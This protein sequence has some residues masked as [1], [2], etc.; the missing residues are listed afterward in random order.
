MSVVDPVV[1]PKL[2]GRWPPARR[3]TLEIMTGRRRSGLV[4]RRG[5]L[6]RRALLAAD[7]IGLV[8]AFFVTQWLFDPT[9]P[10]PGPGPAHQAFAFALTLPLWVVLAK[11]Y[12][13]YDRDE[14]RTDTGIADDF[15]GVFNLVSVGAWIVY[16]GLSLSGV[17]HPSLTKIGTF[18]AVAIVAIPAARGAARNICRSHPSYIQNALIVGAGRVGQEVARKL[19]QHPEYGIDLVGFVDADRVI[20]LP[21]GTRSVPVVGGPDELTDLVVRYDVERVIFAFGWTSDSELLPVVGSLADLGVQI[22]IVP[23][24]FEIIGEN[25]DLHS[26]EGLPLLALRPPR[27]SR[28]S[29]LLKRT[30]DVVGSLVAVVL[31]MPF[32]AAI[33]IAIKLDSRGPVVFRQVR[34]GR[35]QKRFRIWKFRTMVADA[36]AR[37]AEFAHLNKH[38][39]AG[40]DPRMFKIPDDPR[41]T[42]VGRL[43]RRYSLDELP[44]LVNV[45]LGQMSLVGP[46]PLIVDEHAHVNGWKERRLSLKP[47]ITGVWQVLGRD[48]IPFEDMVRMDYLYVTNWTLRND[49]RLILRT[50]AVVAGARAHG[51]R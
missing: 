36:D 49:L 51:G 50:P 24:Y 42:R 41:V 1:S 37:K 28:S 45:L 33:A 26:V 15:S 35:D 10:V 43:L 18:W 3:R 12:G 32:F 23:R 17:G 38:L 22:D 30:L 46:R 21:S 20:E 48:D 7:V 6:V 27:F 39:R 9:S 16:I 2:E 47:G 4:R 34:V 40:G 19:L 44:Q 14:E 5:W 29:L 11:L 13:L 31:L 25:V 8:V